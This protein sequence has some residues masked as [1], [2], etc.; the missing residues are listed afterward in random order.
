MIEV[1]LT[2]QEANRRF[3]RFLQAYLGN[4]SKSLLYK[5][6]RKKRIKLNGAR[7]EGNEITSEGDIVSFYLSE[8]T[9]QKF[10]S[11]PKS[12]VDY[13]PL[14]LIY[15]DE[16]II[17]VNKPVGL[18]SHSDSPKEVPQDTLH[19]RLAY[20]TGG[21]QAAICNRL[22]RNTSG[23]VACGKT[24]SAIQSLNTIFAERKVDKTYLAIVQGKL[25]GSASLSAYLYKDE[26]ENRSYIINS[27]KKGA[28]AVHL[29]YE[30]LKC[31][32]DRS[33]LRVKL[34]TG[35]P[36]Q[37]RAQL[38]YIG[39]PIV[40]DIKYGGKQVSAK[41]GQML[42]CLSLRFLDCKESPLSYLSGKKF[43]TPIPNDFKELI[44]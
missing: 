9:M 38:A 11:I 31:G 35:R 8:E 1:K 32:D 13:G 12:L 29:D 19:E 42:H 14:E 21:R 2:S 25:T 10:L 28:S 6:L 27:P 30:S 44:Q 43:S 7:A 22:D 4:A 41:R 5:L 36:H 33:L 26:A 3:D 18:L 34:H 15:E 40:G 20:Y 37:I 23:L 24:M 16:Q 17:I 39:H